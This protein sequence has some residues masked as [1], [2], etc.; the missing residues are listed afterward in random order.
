MRKR[1]FRISTGSK[2]WDSILADGFQSCSINEVYGEFSEYLLALGSRARPLSADKLA[3][4]GKTQLSHTMAV[5]AQLPKE[6]GGA[7]GK[8]V[9]IDTEGTWR[10]ERIEQ[11]AER[12]GGKCFICLLYTSPS[13]RD[14]LLSR[15]PSSA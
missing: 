14:G 10:P 6:K 13:P 5:I 12:F 9:V 15:M 8:V 7:E 4:C 2:Q 11:I 3:G 1:C